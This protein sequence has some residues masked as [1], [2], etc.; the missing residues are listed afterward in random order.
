MLLMKIILLFLWATTT[1]FTTINN[2]SGINNDDDN[3]NSNNNNN[4]NNA[5]ILFRSSLSSPTLLY[6]LRC[7]SCMENSLLLQFDKIMRTG[8]VNTFNLAIADSNLVQ[9][10]L[11]L[12]N[13]GLGIR[14]VSSLA[15]PAFLDSAAGTA[16]LQASIL[17]NCNVPRIALLQWSRSNGTTEYHRA[18]IPPPS[19]DCSLPLGLGRERLWVGILKGRY[20]NFD[21]L[22]D[23]LNG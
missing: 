15:L 2:S 17:A 1:T 22:I 7:F 5:L 20:I 4:N 19:K 14:R 11:P 13:R 16:S 21:W 9:A 10:T 18:S 3:S 23:W 12:R 8:L 6:S